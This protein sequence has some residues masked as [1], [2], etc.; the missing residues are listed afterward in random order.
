[1]AIVKKA[2]KH[3]HTKGS[4]NAED[5]GK[6][7]PLMDLVKETANVLDSAI[8]DDK[9]PAAMMKKLKED[10]FVFSGAK[11]HAQMFETSRMLLT[12]DG[13]KKSFAQFSRDVAAI[14]KD[15]NQTYL[16]AEYLFATGS[17]QVASQW[18]GFSDDTE[19]YYLQYRTAA[20]SR[21]RD[22]HEKLHNITLPKDDEFWN[23]YGAKNGWNCR[24]RNIEVRAA[25]YPASD[26]KK[27]SELG[28]KATTQLGKDG[29][30]KL[31]IFRY[32]PGKQQVIFPPDHP[33]HKIEG[34]AAAKKAIKSLSSVHDLENLPDNFKQYIKAEKI[35][36]PYEMFS[37]IKQPVKF[38]LWKDSFYRTNEHK[39]VI[40]GNHKNPKMVIIHE[41]AHAID[42]EN[43]FY[44]NP[45]TLDLMGKYY[46]KYGQ[47][48]FAELDSKIKGSTSFETSCVRDTIM[49]IS[50]KQGAGHTLKYFKANGGEN[51]PKEF[52]AH[53]FENRF[54][55]N[56]VFEKFAP[57]MFEDMKN[58]VDEYLNDIE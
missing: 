10:L 41:F 51:R 1:M 4:Y 34:A 47:A 24:C 18:A 46:S 6:D 31:A 30:N 53:C 32:N 29:T 45:K 25:K 48:G 42:A 5:L 52:I 19:R 8:Q 54:A 15:Y 22:S 50:L 21:V 39:V 9:I 2:Y 57:E 26:S 17:A 49:S 55:G 43:K 33:Y 36:L 3:I 40:Q 11:T 7:V 58:L 38:E 13:K 23:Y 28:D 14:Q 44:K 35:D 20:D 27:A 16:Q 12:T 37:K 56:E